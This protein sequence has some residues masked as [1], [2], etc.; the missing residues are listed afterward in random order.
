[1]KFLR[2]Y[3]TFIAQHIKKLME[4]RID[5]L[6]GAC[7]FFINQIT[8]IVFISIVFTQIPELEGYE[9][10]E[11]IFIYGFSLIPRGLDH[12]TTDNLW[13]VAWFVV[14]KGDFD[15]YLIRPISPLVHCIIETIQFDALGEFVM[16][17]IL[18]V[19]ASIKL[20]YEYTIVNVPLMLIAMIFGTLIYTSI[21]IVGAA[22]AFWM[23]QSGSLLQ[24]FYGISDFA[25]YP[26]TVYNG[27]VRNIITYIIPFAFTAYYPCAYLLRG[28]NPLFCIG[29]VV[30]S[31]LILFALSLV[32]WNKGLLAYES[33]GS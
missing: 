23:K 22:L 12:L 20:G 15:K 27:V 14:R 2:L 16:G 17:I 18:M 32:I 8:N 28:D 31:S 21:K 10:Y 1:M 19:I 33:A 3:K 5:F 25:K 24:I 9:Y 13:K 11:I 6:T 26:V 4:Y 30:L 7:S 29:G